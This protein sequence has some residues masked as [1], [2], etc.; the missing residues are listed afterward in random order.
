MVLT[1]FI[2]DFL[3]DAVA[4][5]LGLDAA[6]STTN[7]FLGIAESTRNPATVID[8]SWYSWTCTAAASA[9]VAS[10]ACQGWQLPPTSTQYRQEAGKS[11][12]DCES[13]CL[14]E[15]AQLKQ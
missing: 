8:T 3:L 10:V 2:L 6:S 9:V 13:H 4:E 1:L 7:T 11:C 15:Q 5:I 12:D 14:P